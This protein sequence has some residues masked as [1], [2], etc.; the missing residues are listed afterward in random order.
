MGRV[1]FTVGDQKIERELA[2]ASLVGR[3]PMC[4]VVVSEAS[5]PAFWFEVRYRDDAWMIRLLR[6]DETTGQDAHG[7]TWSIWELGAS[8]CLR[9][10]DGAVA[11][12]LSDD[13]APR[14]FAME[15]RSNIEILE[16]QFESLL[17]DLR[18]DQRERLVDYGVEVVAGRA[19]RFFEVGA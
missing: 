3:H 8:G 17:Y 6:A 10:A 7:T 13:E 18:E 5:V 1:R 11:V 4:T 14:P 9:R 16:H 2:R 15:L 12:E 19:Y